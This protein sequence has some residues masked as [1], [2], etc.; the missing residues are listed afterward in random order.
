MIG[1]KILAAFYFICLTAWLPAQS[2]DSLQRVLNA[3]P[4]GAQRIPLLRQIGE[5]YLGQRDARAITYFDELLTLSQD[6]GDNLLSAY[7]YNRMGVFWLQQNDIRKSS[8]FYFKGLQVT[9]ELGKFDEIKARLNNNLGWN[10]NLM[11]DTT[12]A[13]KYYGNA[14]VYARRINNPQ[15]LGMILNNRAIVLKDMKRYD[16]ALALF[17]ESL[18]LNRRAGNERQVRFNLNNIGTVLMAQRKEV[19]AKTYYESALSLNIRFKDTVE[20]INNLINL[21]K[22][23][24]YL[25]Q[26]SDSDD[27]LKEALH[28][29]LATNYLDQQSRIYATLRDLS[30]A[31]HHDR[32]AY[33]YFVKYQRINDS[34]YQREQLTRTIEGEAKYIDM[35]KDRDLQKARN[36]ITEQRLYL[37]FIVSALGITLVIIFFLWRL[38]R[39]KRANEKVLLDLNREIEAQ[40]K[41]LSL[42]NEKINLINNGLEEAVRNRTAIIQAQNERLL[43]FSNMNSHKIRAPLATLLGLLNLFEDEPSP[44]DDKELIGHLKATAVK[45]DEMIHEVSRQLEREDKSPSE[46]RSENKDRTH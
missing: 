32:D 24:I 30:R 33:D 35:M 6:V 15:V 13:L 36:D 11:S 2:L 43:E 7:A 19:E 29:A 16:S 42:A 25:K 28:L 41:A 5:G 26:F 10:F 39:T 4:G 3:T 44:A 17:E 37:A 45:M 38:I 20:I 14:V 23:N 34:L 9:S 40:S 18:M 46:V 27:Q 22:V 8:D 12:R 1:F 31:T 21:G